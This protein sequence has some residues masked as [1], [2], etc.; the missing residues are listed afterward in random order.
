MVVKEAWMGIVEGS[1]F[2][3]VHAKMRRVKQALAQWSKRTFDNIF[4]KIATLEDVVKAK[5]IQLEISLFE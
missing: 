2:T 1:H 3:I 5:E 4:Q